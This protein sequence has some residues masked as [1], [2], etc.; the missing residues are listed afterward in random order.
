LG[1][2]S[3]PPPQDRPLLAHHGGKAAVVCQKM[4][5]LEGLQPSKPPA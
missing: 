1:S 5:D 4:R 3:A 2:G